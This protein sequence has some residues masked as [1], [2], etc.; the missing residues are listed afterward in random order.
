VLGPF[1]AFFGTGYYTGFGTVTAEIYSTA[2]RATGQGFTYNTGRLASAAAPFTVGSL[3]QT[4][5]FGTAFVL[6]A[7]VFVVAAFFWFW[8]PETRGRELI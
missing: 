2:V 4:H 1:V 3:A 7:A 5:G 6:L 8:I